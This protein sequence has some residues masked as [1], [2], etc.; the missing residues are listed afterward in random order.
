MRFAE[1]L[2][3][4]MDGDA[5]GS[6]PGKIQAFQIILALVIATEYWVKA[7]NAWDELVAAELVALTVATVLAAAVVHGRWRRIA[8]GSFAVLQAWYVIAHFPH[9]GNHRYLEM[10]VAF[11]LA[12][13]DDEDELER[14]LALRSLRW[15]VVTVLFYSGLQKLVHGYWFRGQF[16][17]Y[18]AWREHFRAA[19]ETVLPGAELERLS[20]Y[21]A[22]V[23]DGPYL[24]STPTLAVISN[25]VWILEIAL[26]VLLIPRT[27]R[28]FAWIAACTFVL[29]TEIVAREL[30]FGVE[31]IAALSLFAWRDVTRWMV[32]PAAIVLAVLVCMRLGL[33]PDVL[34]N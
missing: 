20:S 33:V 6:Q 15:I 17:A 3:S 18:S 28:K 26:A 12:F 8:L 1:A 32:V 25:A 23:G 14:Q 24:V 7:L 21:T 11:L 19:L 2:L 34:F 10:V 31:F 9:T 16:L 5:R 30:M 4:R 22:A 13:L 27:T 29:A